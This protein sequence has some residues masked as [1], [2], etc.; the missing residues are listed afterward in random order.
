[1]TTAIGESK[2]SASKKVETNPYRP[3][4]ARFWHGMRFGTWIALLARNRFKVHPLRWGLA[5]T[6]STASIVNSLASP[7]QTAIYGR[8]IRRTQ[9]TEAPIFIIGHWRSGTTLLHELMVLDERFTYPTT[10]ECFIPNDFMVISWLVRWM[11]FLLPAQRPMDNMIT[12]WDRPQEDEFA[13]LNMGV[14]TPYLKMAFPNE[15]RN[16]LEYLDLSDLPPEELD[17][18]KEAM[19]WFLQSITRRTPKRIVLKSPPHTAR[20]K[21][22]LEMFPDARF[23]HIVRD[24]YVLFPSNVK[25][26]KTLYKFQALQEPKYKGL[27]EYVFTCFEHMYRA[28]EEQRQL[29]DPARIYEVRY[30]DLVRDKVGQMRSMYEHLELGNFAAVLPKLEEYLTSVQDYKTNR[31]E[32]DPELREV[33]DRRWGPFMRRYGYCQPGTE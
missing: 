28:F 22:L 21:V 29:L 14:L 8:R 7:I 19:L 10:L 20:I 18:W 17:G 30:E 16:Y 12:G 5:A 27:E 31:Y 33:I 26:W 2:K 13:L 4:A 24:P 11:K 3:W 1:M 15:P 6:V 23:V 25:L 32:I 9:I